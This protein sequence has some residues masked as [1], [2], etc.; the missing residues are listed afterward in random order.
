[1]SDS[2][3]A[4]E[5]LVP[6]VSTCET[7][8][9]QIVCGLLHTILESCARSPP[10]SVVFLGDPAW[11]DR[12]VGPLAQRLSHE[13]SDVRKLAVDCLVA[14]NSANKHNRNVDMI[15]Y[16]SKRLDSDKAKLVHIYIRRAGTERESAR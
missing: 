3:N 8:V 11:M 15:Q 14:F 9:L 1:M 12:L 2:E 10:A 13:R 5:L 16:L 4:L 6:F 7:P